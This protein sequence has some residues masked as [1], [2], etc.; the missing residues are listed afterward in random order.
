MEM[1]G[2]AVSESVGQCPSNVLIKDDRWGGFLDRCDLAEGHS[3]EHRSAQN[4]CE[5]KA[6]R[7]GVGT[8][9]HR[10][11]EEAS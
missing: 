5:P 2:D 10:D 3:G 6:L 4:A 1:E 11:E 7:C 9:D 8:Y